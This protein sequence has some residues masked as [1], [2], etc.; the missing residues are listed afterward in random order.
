MKLAQPLEKT[1]SRHHF[2]WSDLAW[3]IT[4]FIQSLTIGNNSP[5]FGIMMIK[6]VHYC[7]G[8]R[9]LIRELTFCSIP[10]ERYTYHILMK[11]EHAIMQS[12]NLFLIKCDIRVVRA[13][14][15]WV[16]LQLLEIN[17]SKTD[18]D[19]NY[20]LIQASIQARDNQWSPWMALDAPLE[21]IPHSW[22]QARPSID[23]PSWRNRSLIFMNCST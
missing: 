23:C 13:P 8:P 17:Q 1:S 19:Q 5:K 2:L 16:F 7:S 14:C 20:V 11:F 21:T 22:F 18:I 10:S 6:M 15:W 3:S 9:G 4:I 12:G